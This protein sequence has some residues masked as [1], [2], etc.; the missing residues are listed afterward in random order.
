MQKKIN[1]PFI[2]EKPIIE[3]HFKTL[4]N[5]VNLNFQ[6]NFENKFSTV[7]NFFPSTS[8]GENTILEAISRI[9]KKYKENKDYI[10]KIID[11][12]LS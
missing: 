8:N 7:N 1:Y 4:T 9:C 2:F 11:V 10:C 3:H 12:R 6:L 5:G